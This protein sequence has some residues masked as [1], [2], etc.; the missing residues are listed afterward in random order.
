[1][2]DESRI[3]L[4]YS[5]ENLESAQLLLKSSLFNPCLQNCQQCVEKALKA[6]LLENSI[7][8]KKTHSILELRNLLFQNRIA[9]NINEEE[10]DFLDSIYLPSKY[11]LQSVL[12]YYM[13]DENLCE[14]GIAIAQKV[15]KEIQ[16]ILQ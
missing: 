3:W 11:P 8:L 1:M 16:K 10:C 13:P 7:P 4:E 14:Q 2:K 6:L 15:Y 5:K 9:I 12:P